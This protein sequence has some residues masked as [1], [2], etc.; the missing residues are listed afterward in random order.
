MKRLKKGNE[1]RS[2][3]SILK[4]KPIMKDDGV[5]RVGGSISMTRIS[6][7]A[8]NP[9]I[10]PKKDHTTRMLIRY[11]HE[12]DGHCGVEQVLAILREQFS[13]VKARTAIKLVLGR[14]IHCRK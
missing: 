5:M 7:E 8:R 3:R 13:V 14:Y 9:I 10:L 11:F 1:M 6:I 4:L 2:A 12:N